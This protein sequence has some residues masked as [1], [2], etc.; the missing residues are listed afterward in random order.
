MLV[1]AIPL[2]T[3]RARPDANRKELSTRLLQVPRE[4]T[5]IVLP[6]L[7][8]TGYVDNEEEVH[9]LAETNDGETVKFFKE[10]AM[11]FGLWIAFSFIEQ[12]NRSYYIAGILMDEDG[13]IRLHHRKI[14]EKPP[15]TAGTDVAVAITPFGRTALLLCGDIFLDDIGAKLGADLDLLIVP[16]ARCFDGKSPD[17]ERWE[18]EERRA[19]VEAVR[20]LAENTII[21]NAFG[22]GEGNLDFGSSLWVNREKGLMA[23]SAHGSDNLLVGSILRGQRK[24]TY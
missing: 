20:P 7:T 21:C 1:T 4:T 8:L 10:I 17:I 9:R 5:L 2:K 24:P 18:R 3:A 16:M 23:E 14:S 12:E 19:Y 11:Q 6:E 22:D 15:Y 13:I